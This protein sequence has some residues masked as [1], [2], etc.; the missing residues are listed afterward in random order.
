MH[1]TEFLDNI[2]DHCDPVYLE[3]NVITWDNMILRLAE[4]GLVEYTYVAE[5]K[6]S[7][8]NCIQ[9]TKIEGKEVNDDGRRQLR[10]SFTENPNYHRISKLYNERI[11]SIHYCR[12]LILYCSCAN[13]FGNSIFRLVP[14]DV[15]LIIM[16]MV[17][18]N[19]NE[20]VCPNVESLL[21]IKEY[22]EVKTGR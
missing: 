15:F 19:R 7:S 11:L 13:R 9:L 6:R 5:D 18:F 10:Y 8:A 3:S 22:M 14:K 1:L 2:F 20:S 12:K 21:A 4:L 16:K 17:W